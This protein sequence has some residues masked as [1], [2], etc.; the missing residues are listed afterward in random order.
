MI[1]TRHAYFDIV[2]GVLITKFKDN[3]TIDLKIAKE[4]VEDRKSVTK[5]VAFPGLGYAKG[6]RGLSREA[7]TYFT[8]DIAIEGVLAGALI[9]ESNFAAGLINFF[10]KINPP[11]IPNKVFT[12]EEKAMEWL[13]AFKKE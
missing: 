1:E 7:R 8:E 4:I 6:V 12:S 5:G 13:Q 10:L 2:N 3:I 11:K 9:M